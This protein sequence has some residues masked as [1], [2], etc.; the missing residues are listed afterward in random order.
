MLS[1]AALC[2]A[3]NVYHEARGEPLLGQHAVAQVTLNRTLGDHGRVCDVVFA[4]RQF[5]WTNA[6]L[7]APND[8]A[9]RKKVV[10]LLPAEN[11]AWRTAKLVALMTLHGMTPEVIG[12]ADHYYNPSRVTPRWA[13]NMTRVTEIGNHLFYKSK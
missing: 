4:P 2:L 13:E 6:L 1:T 9:R 10:A 11:I 8:V 12:D 7:L 3:L 5:S